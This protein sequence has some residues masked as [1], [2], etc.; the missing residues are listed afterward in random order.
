VQTAFFQPIKVE[1]NGFFDVVLGFLN[2]SPVRMATR[3]GRDI[4]VV[5]AVLLRLKADLK[6]GKPSK[7]HPRC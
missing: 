4:S 2:C 1:Q 7:Q 6:N 3:Q 5:T